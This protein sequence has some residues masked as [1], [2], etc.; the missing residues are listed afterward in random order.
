MPGKD[1]PNNIRKRGKILDLDD[2]TE[3]NDPKW[4]PSK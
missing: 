4:D 3:V 1:N 2:I